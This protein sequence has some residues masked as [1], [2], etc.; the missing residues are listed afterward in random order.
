[1]AIMIQQKQNDPENYHLFKEAFSKK[2][3]DKIISRCS[4]LPEANKA[5]TG[6]GENAV[7][8]GGKVRESMIK[9]IPETEEWSWLYNRMIS[10]AIEANE[11]KFHFDLHS[12]LEMVQYTEYYASEKGHFDWHQ[13]L[14]IGDRPSKR[15]ISITIQLSES[16]EY[17]GG[18]FLIATGG[19]GTGKLD[20]FHVCPKGKGVGILFPSYKMHRVTPVTKGVRKSLVLWIGGSHF[21]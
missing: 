8:G 6:Y 4:N 21:R 7:A 1:M 18:D 5:G 17:E 14:G 9:W 15:K 20:N 11:A 10:M 2:D 13:D 16:D 19:S 12:S 3:V